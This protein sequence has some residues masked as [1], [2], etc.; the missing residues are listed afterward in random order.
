MVCY[1]RN[2]GGI[3][4]KR[5][6]SMEDRAANQGEQHDTAL[7]I[8]LATRL[9]SRFDPRDADGSKMHLLP[10]E[11][12]T[13][14]REALPFPDSIRIVGSMVSPRAVMVIFDAPLSKEQLQA[15]YDEHLLGS[16]WNKP[17]PF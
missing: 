15:F 3:C 14:A 6:F 1:T 2:I 5:R 11:V 16:G 4:S 17:E 9:L 12:P 8:E 7:V 13:E 10:G